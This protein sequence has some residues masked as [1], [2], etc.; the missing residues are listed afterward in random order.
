MPK[1]AAG[2]LRKA[3]ATPGADCSARITIAIA[4]AASSVSPASGARRETR[5][6]MPARFD[7]WLIN[8][9]AGRT[10]RTN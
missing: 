1:P 6:R 7:A 5:K 2:T 3:A 10:T 8:A 4:D 9:R